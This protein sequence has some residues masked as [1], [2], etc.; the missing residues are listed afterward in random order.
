MKVTLKLNDKLIN[1]E[2]LSSFDRAHF[3]SEDGKTRINLDRVKINIC[4]VEDDNSIW[5]R[6]DE[7]V[8]GANTKTF[9]KV[10]YTFYPIK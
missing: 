6:G 5:I 10:D 8:P 4:G 9:R 3:I 7:D 1:G 2:L